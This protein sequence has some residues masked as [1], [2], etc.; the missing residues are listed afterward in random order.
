VKRIAALLALL[1]AVLVVGVPAGTATT[2]PGYNFTI[3][4]TIKKGG[5]IVWSANQVK[6]G[7]LTHFRVTN[8]D[9]V[10]HRFKVGGLGPKQAIRPGKTVKVG[11]YSEQRGQFA[12]RIDGK[13][14][15]WFV[16]N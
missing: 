6:R 15:G 13:I 12:F 4:V 2:A 14:R 5:Q 1:A 3:K 9:K 10:A 7:W 11:A 16:V 8:R